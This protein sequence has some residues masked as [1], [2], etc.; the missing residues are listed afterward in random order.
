MQDWQQLQPQ[1]WQQALSLLQQVVQRPSISPDDQG[2]QSELLHTYLANAGFVAIPCNKPDSKGRLTTNTFYVYFNQETRKQ[3]LVAQLAQESDL[4]NFTR[5]FLPPVSFC[6]AGHTDVVPHGN[7]ADWTFPPYDATFSQNGQ[8]VAYEDL[9]TQLQANLKSSNPQDF[10]TT[11]T[12]TKFSGRGAA[13]MKTGLVASVVAAQLMLAKLQAGQVENLPEDYAICLLVTSDEEAEALVGTKLVV[14]EL[15]RLGETL[16]WC[17]VAEPSCE[18]FFGDAIQIGSRGDAGLFLTIHGKGGHVAYPH[19]VTNP[20]HLA[21]NLIAEFAQHY[22]LDPG[23]SEFPPSTMHVVNLHAGDGTTNLV[24]GSCRLALNI[25][26]NTN[27]TYE[28]LIA[29]LKGMIEKHLP[30]GSYEISTECSGNCFVCLPQEPI[31][32][33][34]REAIAHY[35]P[36]LHE[37]AAQANTMPAEQV[38]LSTEGGTSDARFIIDICPQ[39]L[40]FGVIGTTCHQVDEHTYVD[41]YFKSIM[42]YQD[43]LIRCLQ[44]SA[45]S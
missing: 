18:Q 3:A 34:M 38:K 24:P 10:D 5:K 31:V 43:T 37:R 30:A 28:T 1:G 22:E 35:V 17:L 7:L 44:A 40:S 11:A 4:Q 2:C 12:H 45:R 20:I 27:F 32:A 39:I 25:R 26:Y 23:N 16:S 33:H 19:Q 14:E 6:F 15:Q 8:A 13:D 42:I 29:H 9:V 21:S 36:T 41:Q